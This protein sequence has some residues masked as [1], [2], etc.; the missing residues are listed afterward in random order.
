M[1]VLLLTG[2][3]MKN[4]KPCNLFP[5][6]KAV[7]HPFGNN[8]KEFERHF[9]AGAEK[10]FGRGRPV[11]D[12]SGSSNLK[13]LKRLVTS[14]L[15][16]LTKAQ[17]LA[18]LPPLTRETRKVPVSSRCQLQYIQA[19]KSLVRAK[20]TGL[21]NSNAAKTHIFCFSLLQANVHAQAATREDDNESVLGAVQ[22]L[23]VT[24]SHAKIG[25]TVEVAIKVLEQEPAL[26]LFTSFAQ[27]AKQVH[28]QL[29]A[30]G[31]EGEL[32]TGETPAKK[33]Q[34]MVDNFQVRR[35]FHCSPNCELSGPF[36]LTL[37][38]SLYFFFNRRDYHQFLFALMVL[39]VSD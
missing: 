34:G 37:L 7:R 14:H 10:N 31:W 38:Y 36:I 18:E 4:G 15:L 3:P 25:A 17:C 1:G 27:V 26:V 24:C 8:Q 13:Q 30:S 22:R 28:Q 29:T 6:L 9:C 20:A 21:V 11:W 32:L 2:T 33:R 19:L 35:S 23:R 12:A 16:H 39:V 5:L